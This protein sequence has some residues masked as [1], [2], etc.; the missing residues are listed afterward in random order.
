MLQQ[1]DQSEEAL[2]ELLERVSA[3]RIC[4]EAPQGKRLPHEPRPVIRAS[5]TARLCIA[6]QAPGTRVHA[7]GLPFNDPSGDRLRQWMAIDRDAFY[8]TAR[9]TIV[10]MGFCFPGQDAAMAAICRHVANA[11]RLGM[12]QSSRICHG[13]SS[14]LRSAPM[15]RPI[16]SD[17]GR[18]GSVTETVRDWR[19]VGEERLAKGQARVIPLPHPSWRNTGWLKKNAWFEDELLPVLRSAVAE[20]IG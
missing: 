20:A 16:I 12:T 17:A 1:R 18:R 3:C 5:V 9:V 8:D 7:T 19:A 13:S 11:R 14:S 15:R 2:G 6:G 4:R 10:P